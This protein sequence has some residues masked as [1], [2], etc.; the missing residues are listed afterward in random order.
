MILLIRHG[1]VAFCALTVL[2]GK[3]N[4]TFLL[5]MNVQNAAQFD[6]KY[7]VLY[8]KTT[9]WFIWLALL[10]SEILWNVEASLMYL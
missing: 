4:I 8:Q 10:P 3:E 2:E 7:S 1:L 6:I 5:A 9:T